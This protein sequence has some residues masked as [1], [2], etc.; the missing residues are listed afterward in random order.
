MQLS[1]LY[2]GSTQSKLSQDQRVGVGSVMA[3]TVKPTAPSSQQTMPLM[4]GSRNREDIAN[5]RRIRECLPDQPGRA[6]ILHIAHDAADPVNILKPVPCLILDNEEDKFL[7]GDDVLKALRIDIER[8]LELLATPTCDDGDYDEVGPE[9]AAG[10][11]DA[12]ATQKA[13]EAL[14]QRALDEGFPA[15]KVERLRTILFAYYVWRLVLVNDPPANVEPKR[16]RVEKGCRSRWACAALSVR[17]RGGDN[18]RQTVDYKPFNSRTGPMA[19]IMP[20]LH[21]D[22]ENM[23]GS[24]HFGLFGFSKGYH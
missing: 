2:S 12:G 8:Q 6:R 19:G 5:L 7:L 10:E 17:K 18:F 13:V 15:V 22:L 24:N 23:R 21:V 4:G 20:N 11:N 3:S 9:V 14:I 1:G 16:V